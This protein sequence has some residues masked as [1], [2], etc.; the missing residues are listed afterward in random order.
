MRISLKL[1]AIP[2]DE[3]A[4]RYREIQAEGEAAEQND[5]PDEGDDDLDTEGRTQ[6]GLSDSGAT[7]TPQRPPTTR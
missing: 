1:K 3:I 5:P 2:S 7:P 6:P 4:R